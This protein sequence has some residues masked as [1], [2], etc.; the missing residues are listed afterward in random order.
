M[1]EV[2][3]KKNSLWDRKTLRM[4]G[5][6]SRE[7]KIESSYKYFLTAYDACLTEDGNW[8]FELVFLHVVTMFDLPCASTLHHVYFLF[9]CGL[10][11]LLLYQLLSEVFRSTLNM[12]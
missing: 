1:Y 4:K 12:C 6:V 10:L 9:H 7:K 2:S 5:T 11:K 8:R 3:E